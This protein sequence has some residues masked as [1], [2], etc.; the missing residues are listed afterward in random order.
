ME[1]LRVGVV[2]LGRISPAHIRAVKASADLAE[3][4]AFVSRRG[5]AAAEAARKHGVTKVY[6]DLEEALAAR[7]LDAV[8]LCSPN[9]LHAPQAIAAARAGC[10]VLVEKPLANTLDEADAMIEAAAR[11]H[12][13]LMVAQCRRFTRAALEAKARLTEIGPVVSIVHTLAVRFA[14]ALTDWWPSA[15]KTG[16]LVLGLNAPHVVD[17]MLW[18]IGSR[19]TRVQATASRHSPQWEGEDE[20][21]LL[22]DF[23]DGAIATGHLS[24]NAIHGINERF[25]LAAKGTMRMT[26][27]TRLMVNDRVVVD[28]VYGPY[29]EGGPNFD[30]QT[31]EFLTAIRERR[32]PIA[33]AS[34]VRTCVEVLDAARRAI[35]L[36]APVELPARSASHG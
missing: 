16:G 8:V 15:E 30:A 7:A 18:L 13:V 34:E 23:P 24:F 26:D 9:H 5:A 2:G 22:L 33:A 27:E 20:A 17:T 31:R 32:T 4:A 6:Q 25:I 12:V 10:H 28:E 36:R 11:H 1:K 21:A 14:G 35:K 19:P 29:L 3:L